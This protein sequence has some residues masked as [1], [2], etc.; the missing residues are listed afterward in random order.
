MIRGVTIGL[1]AFGMAY[2]AST[3]FYFGAVHPCEIYKTIVRS[4]LDKEFLLQAL[5]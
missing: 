5:R 1:L 4:E 2:L 3:W